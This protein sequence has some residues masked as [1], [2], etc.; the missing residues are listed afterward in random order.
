[1]A[2]ATPAQL[3]STRATPCAASLVA[4]PSATLASSATLTLTKMPPIA[5]AWARPVSS[6]RSKIAKIGRDTSEL[7]SL[8][9]NSYTVFC[10]K[11]Q[12][13]SNSNHYQHYTTTPPTEHD[14][15]QQNISAIETT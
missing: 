15:C 6:F 5:A 4:R 1:M 3:T 13:T 2:G 9:R 14:Y 11:K 12:K 10:L 8:M 7:Q